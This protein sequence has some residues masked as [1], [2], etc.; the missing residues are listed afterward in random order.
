MK[1]KAHGAEG[2]RHMLRLRA[3][4]NVAIRP[5]RQLISVSLNIQTSVIKLVM[6][7][8]Q[9]TYP[10]LKNLLVMKYAGS[11]SQWHVGIKGE[12]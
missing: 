8:S 5:H 6:S 3:P 11:E 4:R 9:G 12:R 1:R 10:G 2:P 7:L